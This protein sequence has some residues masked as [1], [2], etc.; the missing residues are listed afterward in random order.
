[1]YNIKTVP[2]RRWKDN[3]KVGLKE[4]KRASFLDL[5]DLRRGPVAGSCAHDIGTY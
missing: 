5:C 2:R 3:S 4:V 1:M